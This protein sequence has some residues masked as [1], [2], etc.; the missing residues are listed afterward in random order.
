MQ[1]ALHRG[2]GGRPAAGGAAE[3]PGRPPGRRAQGG[4]RGC[5]E[6]GRRAGDRPRDQ[7]HPAQPVRRGRGRLAPAGWRHL[8]QAAVAALLLHAAA[9]GWV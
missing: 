1:G 4:R 6:T 7:P 8:L 5:D 2:A 9:A 3:A